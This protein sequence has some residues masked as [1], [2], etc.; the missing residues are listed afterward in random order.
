MA[1]EGEVRMLVLG[2]SRFSQSRSA[3]PGVIDSSSVSLLPS[4]TPGASRF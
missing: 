4:K 2:D 3:W 1:E